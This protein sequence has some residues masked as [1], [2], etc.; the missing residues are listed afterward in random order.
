MARSKDDQSAGEWVPIFLASLRSTGVVKAACGV[1]D[2]ERKTAY[3][4]RKADPAF[5]EDWDEA[6]EEA[7]DVL[8]AEMR[9]RALAGSDRLLEFA[10]TGLRPDRYGKKARVIVEAPEE[11]PTADD[12]DDEVLAA[13]IAA[14]EIVSEERAKGNEGRRRNGRRAK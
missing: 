1:A 11:T 4:R 13:V 7:A 6:I 10:L 12:L 14:G 3:R 5:A 8:E 2:I 9:R